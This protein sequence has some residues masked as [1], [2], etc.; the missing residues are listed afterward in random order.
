[1][2]LLLFHSVTPALAFP[3]YIAYSH[4]LWGGPGSPYK[5]LSDS[6]VAWGEQLK[7]TKKYLDERGVKDCWF[8]YFAE[9]VAEPVYYGIPCKPLPTINTPWLHQPIRDPR[10]EEPRVA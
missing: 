7:A 3:P 5:Y 4:A 6:N 9:G 2:A 8:V 1:M 10:S